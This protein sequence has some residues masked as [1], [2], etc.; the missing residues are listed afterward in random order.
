MNLSN[1]V[2]LITGGASGI[3]KGAALAFAEHGARLALVDV[4]QED[5][6]K[7]A[8][9]VRRKGTQVETFVADVSDADQ[10]RRACDGAVEKFGRL[11]IVYANAGVNGVWAPIEELSP[12]EFDKT[13]AINLR[14]TFLTI[15]YA[16]PH[17]RRQGGAVVVT[18]SVNGTRTFSNTGA[19]AYST[20]KAGQVAMAKMLAVEL[21]NYG[22]RVNVI[23]PG[24]IS[25]NIGENTEQRDVDQIKVPAEYPEGTS[26]LTGSK[27]GT[28]D[29]VGQLALFLVSDMAAHITGEVVYI[30]AGSSLVVG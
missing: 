7:V 11:D 27:P 15:K 9:E 30:D 13:I 28:I 14:G 5:L 17:L 18:S 8:E 6:D 26:S 3:G 22:I 25:T 20:S 29:Q 24:A 2:A 21:G 12:E 19:T 1:R 23:C 10:V 16:V 4:V